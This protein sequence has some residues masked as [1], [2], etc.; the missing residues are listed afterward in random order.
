MS[1]KDSKKKKSYSNV[2]PLPN[3]AGIKYSRKA[4]L[5]KAFDPKPL[6]DMAKAVVNWVKE[7]FKSA[8]PVKHYTPHKKYKG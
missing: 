4:Q 8:K 5:K 7:D 6:K 3:K 2:A 1:L